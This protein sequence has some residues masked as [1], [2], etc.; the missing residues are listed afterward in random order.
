MF[1]W[2]FPEMFTRYSLKDLWTCYI[3]FCDKLNKSIDLCPK[4]LLL[5]AILKVSEN[6]QEK[7]L[8]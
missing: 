5:T 6:F 3:F 7:R 2:N 4:A 1:Y 8:S